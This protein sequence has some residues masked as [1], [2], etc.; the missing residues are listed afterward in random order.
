[1][2]SHHDRQV[3]RDVLTDDAGQ[4]FQAVAVAFDGDFDPLGGPETDLDEQQQHVQTSQYQFRPL[5]QQRERP[6]HR[7]PCHPDQG[8]DQPS[9]ARSIPLVPD[10]P[11]QDCGGYD[12]SE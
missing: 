4:G 1:M 5:E 9:P 11:D 7:P 10:E 3:V 8:D 12:R 2:V 6:R